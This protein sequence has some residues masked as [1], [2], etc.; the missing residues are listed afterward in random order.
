MWFEVYCEP[1]SVEECIEDLLRHTPDVAPLAGGTD[2]IPQ[3]K[4]FTRSTKAVVNLMAIDRLSQSQHCE[5]GSVEIGAMATLRNLAAWDALGGPL[6]G[7]REG[8]GSVSSVQVRNV[9]TL[10]GNSCNASPAADTVP[11]L[12]AADTEIDI[13]G[14]EGRRRMLLEE[15]FV[16]PGATAL[17]TGEVLVG[18]RIPSPPPPTG[19]SYQKHAIRGNSDVAIAGVAARLTLDP[20]GSVAEARVVLGAVAPTAIRSA[21]AEQALVGA[22]PDE[23]AIEAAAALA[24]E[25]CR[26]I[27]DQRASAAY[28]REMVRVFTK[29]AVRVAAERA[30]TNGD[31]A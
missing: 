10:G 17:A 21:R 18:F 19:S 22:T 14:P 27:T 15:F 5:D 11:G 7:I 8:I 23:D 30:P 9:A 12:I 24:A 25:D 20:D 13:E 1:R 26:P 28:R 3:F 6:A 4:D 29:R 2:L 16:G 31:A